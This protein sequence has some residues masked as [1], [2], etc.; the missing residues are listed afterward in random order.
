MDQKNKKKGVPRQDETYRRPFYDRRRGGSL[1][2]KI[3][4]GGIGRRM[5][6]DWSWRRMFRN[7]F[8]GFYKR[9]PE[10]GARSQVKERNAMVGRSGKNHGGGG[11]IWETKKRKSGREFRETQN[12]SGYSSKGCPRMLFEK[13]KH[14]TQRDPNKP[15]FEKTWT[16]EE[17]VGSQPNVVGRRS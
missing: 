1:F 13:G 11:G 10:K 2:E 4:L 15:Y 16:I 3:R 8:E 7:R 5:T 12:N 9:L 6:G 17:E 14:G